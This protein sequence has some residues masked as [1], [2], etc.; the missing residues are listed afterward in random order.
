MKPDNYW[1]G[2]TPL[3]SGLVV[4]YTGTQDSEF[5]SPPAPGTLITLIAEDYQMEYNKV[6]ICRWYDE[7]KRIHLCPLLPS[8]F[9]RAEEPLDPRTLLVAD[10]Y[11]EATG[12]VLDN[13]ALEKAI[14]FLLQK[15]E[16]VVKPAAMSVLEVTLLND[17]D[18]EE[19]S[20]VNFPVTL[21]LYPDEY[22]KEGNGINIKGRILN[23]IPGVSESCSLTETEWYYFFPHEATYKET[24]C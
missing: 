6:W 21:R 3:R 12:Y 2:E 19:L 4:K 9:K 23:M 18:F 13:R 11:F 5:Y 24:K 14:D 20:D 22:K 8:T 15:R 1:D 7:N 10:R 17:A 16:D